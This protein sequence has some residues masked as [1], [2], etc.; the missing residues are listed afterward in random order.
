MIRKALYSVQLYKKSSSKRTAAD[1]RIAVDSNTLYLTCDALHW[2]QTHPA[3]DKEKILFKVDQAYAGND[4]GDFFEGGRNVVWACRN[5]ECSNP[6]DCQRDQGIFRFLKYE[7]TDSCPW[8]QSKDIYDWEKE[9]FQTVGELLAR[10]QEGKYRYETWK[11]EPVNINHNDEKVI[12]EILDVWTDPP[13][14]AIV[15]LLGIDWEKAE[16]LCHKISQKL[17]DSGSMELLTGIGM[18]SITFKIHTTEE[19]FSDTL[20]AY[21]GSIDPV[22]GLHCFEICKSIRGCGHAIIETGEPAD[23]T[24]TFRKVLSGKTADDLLA[25]NTPGLPGLVLDLYKQYK[26]EENPEKRK[27]LY[28][29]YKKAKD[30]A[31]SVKDKQFEHNRDRIDREKKD[32]EEERKISSNLNPSKKGNTMNDDKPEITVRSDK[33]VNKERTAS[34]RR[35][36]GEGHVSEKPLPQ[37]TDM[38]VQLKSFGNYDSTRSA[39]DI[40]LAGMTPEEKAEYY[41]FQEFKKKKNAHKAV[42]SVPTLKV[43]RD[44]IIGVLKNAAQTKKLV[45]Q[46][47]TDSLIE[48]AG[49][50]DATI[51]S[52]TVRK[53]HSNSLVRLAN[54]K[55]QISE[56]ADG[57]EYIL[58]LV[59]D[60]LLEAANKLKQ[61]VN[62]VTLDGVALMLT[63]IAEDPESTIEIESEEPHLTRTVSPEDNKIQETGDVLEHIEPESLN[64]GEDSMKKSAQAIESPEATRTPAPEQGTAAP[65]VAKPNTPSANVP[66]VKGEG[67]SEG[68]EKTPGSEEASEHFVNA[69]KKRL[70]TIDS[71][72]ES[73]AGDLDNLMTERSKVC[74]QLRSPAPEWMP[75]NKEGKGGTD[76]DGNGIDKNPAPAIASPVQ[77]DTS[78]EAS[79]GNTASG[80]DLDGNG[81]DKNAKP[82]EPHVAELLKKV[83]KKD[84]AVT[85]AD[86]SMLKEM[87]ILAADFKMEPTVSEVKKAQTQVENVAQTTGKPEDVPAADAAKER[88]VDTQEKPES[89]DSYQTIPAIEDPAKDRKVEL[90][91][92]PGNK[93]NVLEKKLGQADEG[94]IKK[95]D[96]D[97][98][99]KGQVVKT[100]PGTAD[101]KM[102]EGQGL[103]EPTVIGE[104][105]KKLEENHNLSE[106]TEVGAASDKQEV[107]L[108][109]DKETKVG[110]DNMVGAPGRED[111]TKTRDTYP[112]A[113]SLKSAELKAEFTKVT[114]EGKASTS[115]WTVTADGLPVLK[116]AARVAFPGQVIQRFG[117]F[118]SSEYGENLI[119]ALR[120]AG[121]LDLNK[122]VFGDA[123]KV[124]SNSEREA[125]RVAQ[126]APA[127]VAPSATQQPANVAPEVSNRIMN[128][129]KPGI[130]VVDLLASLA[131]PIIAES[132]TLSPSTFMEELVNIAT[133]QEK[134][135]ELS[136]KLN[137]AVEG[138]KAS[139]GK[140]L[141]EGAAAAVPAP[142]GQPA[143][144]P[145]QAATQPAMVVAMKKAEEAE[146]RYNLKIAALRVAPLVADEQKVGLIP[147]Y[148]QLHAE[149]MSRTAA[150]T[151]S[152]ELFEARVAELIGLPE[153]SFLVVENTIKKTIAQ[154]RSSKNPADAKRQASWNK[155]QEETGTKVLGSLQGD[156]AKADEYDSKKSRFGELSNIKW[157]VANGI[158]TEK[159]S[160]AMKSFENR[161]GRSKE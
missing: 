116:V 135:T 129:A 77:R 4:N 3:T 106:P 141:E 98:E 56:S 51:S 31:R 57:S 21:K 100:A 158:D 75:G 22:S 115:H 123:A 119:Q 84:S 60:A 43:D 79:P 11:G 15:E 145:T 24:A 20:K 107:A 40:K 118:S 109:W 16:R 114:A 88:K 28:Q 69:M 152:K 93:D 19:E 142:G 10:T 155:M 39:E 101:E 120:E 78:N 68:A 12:G 62:D 66:E 125:L 151:K 122:N 91:V 160:A 2:E 54:R 37:M 87:G 17:V 38:S 73:G 92:Q 61:Q 113:E 95:A 103:H 147:N 132:E 111:T 94:L 27:I 117:E 149:G 90:E 156:A 130:S 124:Y 13:E 1:E 76:L 64:Q 58:D 41:D 47:L 139:A 137:E 74:A 8:C 150:A 127:T 45:G 6:Y 49:D 67:R 18:D 30:H 63:D 29:Q 9:T 32:W 97:K 153:E 85:S 81:I 23:Q 44:F 48:L 146:K 133:S 86:I 7:H 5:K 55:A 53:S 46:V 157:K 126:V 131:A 42:S 71:M 89:K 96:E 80:K 72:I 136:T 34:D 143:A 82:V 159:H 121:S 33:R 108:V 65:A 104:A 99:N 26:E 83:A 161:D 52:L 144:A 112:D 70:A 140:P 25:E 154:A 102:Q 35:V 59:A 14:K 110:D 128:D 134:V 50:R 138:L 36:E 148:A 105:D